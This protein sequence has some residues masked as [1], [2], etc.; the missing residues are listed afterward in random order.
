[1][2]HLL[3]ST[4]HGKNTIAS[5]NECVQEN[6]EGKCQRVYCQNF[7]NNICSCHLL[8]PAWPFY[9]LFTWKSLSVLPPP[10]KMVENVEHIAG[11]MFLLYESGYKWATCFWRTVTNRIR[12]WTFKDEPS[13]H[14]RLKR[15]W[16]ELKSW[17]SCNWCK[18]GF[19]GHADSTPKKSR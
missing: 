12:S 18:N 5:S 7:V 19:R 9:D 10:R 13:V 17:P 2:S 4:R 1:M 16:S 15:K 6:T 8:M 3:D 14:K 11:N